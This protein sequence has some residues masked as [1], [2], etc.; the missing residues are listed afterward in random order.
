MVE[1]RVTADKFQINAKTKHNFISQTSICINLINLFI[2]KYVNR[3]EKDK[4]LNEMKE[5]FIQTECIDKVINCLY[6][7]TVT[8]TNKNCQL[9]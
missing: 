8:N 9:Q 4:I 5:E 2:Q 6:P 7:I 3:N 1:S